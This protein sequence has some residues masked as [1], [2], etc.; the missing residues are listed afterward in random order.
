MQSG[1][2]QTIWLNLYGTGS[3]GA[4]RFEPDII[5]FGELVV[6]TE[7]TQVRKR[8]NEFDMLY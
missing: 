6:G 5:D 2:S 3:G 7:V 4:L 1:K 8:G